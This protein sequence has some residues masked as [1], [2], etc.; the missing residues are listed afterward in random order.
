MNERTLLDHIGLADMAYVEEAV[1]PVRKKRCR[2]VLTVAAA[3]LALVLLGG[4]A[5]A[6]DSIDAIRAY[7]T[8]QNEAVEP[9]LRES[10]LTVQSGDLTMRVD[11]CIADRSTFVFT[12]SL[13]GVDR[14][15][16]V[17]GSI[18]TVWIAK[19]GERIPN[20]DK[21]YGAYTEGKGWGEELVAHAISAYDDAD[22]TFLVFNR[23][24]EGYTMDDLSAVEVTCMGLTLTVEVGEIV[25]TYTLSSVDGS[26]AA[27]D[28]TASAIGYSFTLAAENECY[29]LSLIR[30][31]GTYF[32]DGAEDWNGYWG[33]ASRSGD[34]PYSVYGRWGGEADIAIGILDLDQYIGIRV[35]DVDYFFDR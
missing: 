35:N 15:L 31:D 16:P 24:P 17:G 29:D 11:N 25:E 3:C 12:L 5:Y 34:E 20:Y 4:I 30:E 22:A 2:N 19:S 14:K 9:L 23:A 18:D 26:G 13:A 10:M 7:F 8:P 32:G 33:S 27:T 1:Y 6:T 28:F 21:E